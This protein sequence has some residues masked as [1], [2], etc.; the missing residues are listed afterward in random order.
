MMQLPTASAIPGPAWRLLQGGRT[1]AAPAHFQEAEPLL[2]PPRS[3]VLP[4]ARC[5]LSD[6]TAAV[7]CH[8][9]APQQAG[10]GGSRSWGGRSPQCF[11]LDCRGV[12][13]GIFFQQQTR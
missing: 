9:N 4:P 11:S 8:R 13:T 2:L 3:L 6:P 5:L 7:G 12:G 1:K 10:L